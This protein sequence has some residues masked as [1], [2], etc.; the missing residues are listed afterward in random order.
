[1][2][3]S[4]TVNDRYTVTFSSA[5]INPIGT[6]RPM[7]PQT[8]FSWKEEYAVFLSTSFD[9]GRQ[10]SDEGAATLLTAF[11]QPRVQC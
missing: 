4:M 8:A 1:M 7:G 6:Q 9:E 5:S 10:V 11:D 3:F 2:L